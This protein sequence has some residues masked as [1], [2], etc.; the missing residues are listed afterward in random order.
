MPPAR[1]PPRQPS[2]QPRDL[3]DGKDDKEVE[4]HRD[5]HVPGPGEPFCVAAAR[6]DQGRGNEHGQQEDH[7]ATDPPQAAGPERIP[8]Q[9]LPEVEVNQADDGHDHPYE[10]DHLAHAVL[11]LTA[12]LACPNDSQACA[13]QRSLEV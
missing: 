3:Q 2:H 7:Q 9:A 6:T 12:G 11:T 8:D 4:H 13:A 1:A 10:R 5:P